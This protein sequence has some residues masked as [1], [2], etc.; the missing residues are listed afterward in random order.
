MTYKHDIDRRSGIVLTVA[1]NNVKGRNMALGNSG[2]MFSLGD[3]TFWAFTYKGRRT[4]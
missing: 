4:L 2:I 1:L 3:D